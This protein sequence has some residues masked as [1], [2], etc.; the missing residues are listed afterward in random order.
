MRMRNYARD[1]RRDTSSRLT[2]TFEC[3]YD[4]PK[5]FLRPH[6]SLMDISHS[7]LL[8]AQTAEAPTRVLLERSFLENVALVGQALASVVVLVL[9]VVTAMT[10]MALRRA[11][12]ELTRLVRNSSSDITAAIHDAREVADELRTMTHRLRGSA[13]TVKAGVDV[14]RSASQMMKRRRRR[15]RG[16]REEGQSRSDDDRGQDSSPSE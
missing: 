2:W 16:P 4:P 12:D 9:L 8:L 10:L 11:L 13:D 3:E 14:A 1:G 6:F 15:R 7:F 5:Q